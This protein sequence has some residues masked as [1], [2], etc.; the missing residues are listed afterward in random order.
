M[1]KVDA[2]DTVT[3]WY[4]TLYE[5]WLANLAVYPLKKSVIVNAN[6]LPTYLRFELLKQRV[7]SFLCYIK[8]LL[9]FG[10]KSLFPMRKYPNEID[11]EIQNCVTL[12]WLYQT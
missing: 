7:F 12:K 5:A 2:V 9:N 4:S 10:N 6:S 8:I 3:L 1:A 11:K